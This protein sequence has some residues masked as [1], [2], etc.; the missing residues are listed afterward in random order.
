MTK[1]ERETDAKRSHA[2]KKFLY[3][4]RDSNVASSFGETLTQHNHPVL[5]VYNFAK[6]KIRIHDITRRGCGDD[7][8]SKCLK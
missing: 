4:D 8:A 5:V 2:R 6:K 3:N 1:D 7:S